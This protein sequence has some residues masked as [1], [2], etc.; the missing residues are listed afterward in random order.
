MSNLF[1]MYEGMPYSPPTVL[2][3]P[4]SATS[5][6][7]EVENISV[8]PPAPNIAVIGVDEFAETVIYQ[9]MWGNTLGNVIRGV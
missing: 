6:D 4:I 7:I 3:Q 5:T 1:P 9:S 2:L 8:F